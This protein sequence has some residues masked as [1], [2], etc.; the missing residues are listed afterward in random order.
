MSDDFDPYRKWLG[1]KSP[2][3]PPNYYRM[4]GLELFEDDLETIENAADRQMAHVRTFQTGRHSVLSQRILNELAAARLCLLNAD[5][6]AAY[7]LRLRAHGFAAKPDST[8]P[9]A[10]SAQ[11]LPSPV[12]RP[13]MPTEPQPLLRAPDDAKRLS[14]A[15]ERQSLSAARKSK[16]CERQPLWIIG[17]GVILTAAI[18]GG[19]WYLSTSRPPTTVTTAVQNERV[20]ASEREPERQVVADDRPHAAETQSENRSRKDKEAI[21]P[22]SPEVVPDLQKQSASIPTVPAG[23]MLDV[24]ALIDPARDAFLGQWSLDSNKLVLRPSPLTLLELPCAVPDEYSLTLVSQKGEG[25]NEL[26]IGLVF[27]SGQALVVIDAEDGHVSG[28]D[29]VDD[30]PFDQ[31][32][33][34]RRGPT[35]LAFKEHT[36][37]CTV[38]RN[39][40]T[41]ACD[42]EPVIDWRGKQEQLS[43]DPKW[44]PPNK[45]R[46]FLAGGPGEYRFL[47]IEA[48]SLEGV[49]E[50]TVPPATPSR[51]QAV[52]RSKTPP[53]TSPI[54]SGEEIRETERRL[55]A[56][57]DLDWQEAATPD[58]KSALAE[59][60]W[61]AIEPFRNDSAAFFVL[62]TAV[63]DL[64][65]EGR[66]PP[67]AFDAV[68]EL[69]ERFAV[70]PLAASVEV[71]ERLAKTLKE[72][73]ALQA[74]CEKALELVDDAMAEGNLD[75]ARRLSVVLPSL[76]A[77]SRDSAFRRRVQDRSAEV[78]RLAR[79]WSELPAAIEILRQNS[80]DPHA[81]GIFGKYLATVLEDWNEALPKLSRCGDESWT[82][83]ARQDLS[84]PAG[85]AEQVAAGDLWWHLAT[86]LPSLEKP[87]LQRRAAE[88]YRRALPYLSGASQIQIQKRL[89]GI[90]SEKP[91]ASR[92]A[93]NRGRKANRRQFERSVMANRRAAEW[94]LSVGGSVS[95]VS[96]DGVER[97]AGKLAELP[98][99]PFAVTRIDLNGRLGITGEGL[100]NL[101]E[102]TE[103]KHLLLAGTSVTD[104]DFVHFADMG[105]LETID[106][107]NTHLSGE[108][109]EHLQPMPTLKDLGLMHN[110]VG[111]AAT[112]FIS[113]CTNLKVLL[114]Q[115]ATIT[116]AGLL[117]LQGLARLERL[118]LTGS[119][120]TDAGL[121]GLSG[122]SSLKALELSN[123]P[124]TGEGFKQVTALPS[125]EVLHLLNDPVHDEGIKAVAPFTSLQV[126]LVQGGTCQV[127]DAGL[128]SLSSLTRLRELRVNGSKITGTAF[129]DLKRLQA[130]E[131][132]GA[133]STPFND[134]GARAL[135][136]LGNLRELSVANSAIT[137]AALASFAKLPKLER[138]SV[139]GVAISIDALAQFRRAMPK[140]AVHGP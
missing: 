41:V 106:L 34:T 100:A 113:G 43:L 45:R 97:G 11:P 80:D 94:V 57:P 125:L 15:I 98:Q 71:V 20:F 102:L 58:E 48:R 131:L 92:V 52:A 73:D 88:W 132:F 1:I 86:K 22:S 99:A 108:G 136:T 75:A 137:D 119:K 118:N 104:A 6:K 114:A 89:N 70:D 55:R 28:L 111:D 77:K 68:D 139:Q 47:R 60:L 64:A 74:L 5:R 35:L 124:L 2:E 81:N 56:S 19:F 44:Q 103:V 69:A 3:R 38:R 12:P 53:K 90:D 122:M 63:R 31:N 66:N 7:D 26:R 76:A 27:G 14:F 78:K 25:H 40:I 72:S 51:G 39:H 10:V 127:T 4:L 133:E 93:G 33:T 120:I 30:K 36:T 109:F 135:A 67:L 37:V 54:P 116:D 130:L 138:L 126:L 123:L 24:L 105:K 84:Q 128:S 32:E 117:K 13:S 42:G 83:A 129:G 121:K 9:R 115:D 17:A 110:G 140:C 65:V 96:L 16:K 85:A 62:L 61:K 21:S 46:L 8:A 79:Q 50:P 49:T 87:P 82:V 29:R 112:P 23:G 18:A 107:S 101:S 59:R 134:E 95:V 91:S